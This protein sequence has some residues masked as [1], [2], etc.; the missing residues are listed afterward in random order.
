M[1]RRRSQLQVAGGQLILGSRD[2]HVVVLLTNLNRSAISNIRRRTTPS[3]SPL[4]KT[5][6]VAPA[7]RRQGAVV[8][9]V[10]RAH[11]ATCGPAV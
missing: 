1:A 3:V 2:F 6:A 4:D 10:R 8:R 5:M 9:S 7:Q 11:A